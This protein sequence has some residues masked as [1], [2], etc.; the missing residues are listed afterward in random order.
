[1][2]LTDWLKRVMRRRLDDDDL[3]DEIRAHLAMA[4]RERMADGADPKTARQASLKEFGNV[5]LTTE[6]ARQVWTPRWVETLRNIV[7]DSRYAVRSLLKNPV[8]SLTVVAVLTLGIG[9]NAAVFTMVKSM[10]LTPLAGVENSA[11]LRVVYGETSAGRDVGISYPDYQYL[12]DHDTATTGMFAHRFVIV[13]MG[14]GRSAHPAFAEAVT[15][16]YF[17]KLGVRAAFGRVFSADDEAAP[18][19][20]S[21]AV[22][23]HALWRRELAA[24]P[25]IVGKTIE[26][27]NQLLTIVG[28]AAPAFH[29]MIVSYDV[30]VFLPVT[31]APTLGVT[32][33]SNETTPSGIL[34]DRRAT[35]LYAFGWLRPGVSMK[36]ASAEYDAIWTDASRGRTLE[37]GMTKMT[38]APFLKYP[39]SAQATVFP[40]LVALTAMATLVLV[41]ACANIGGLVVVR[42]VSRRGEIA[43]RL[44]LGA[45]RVRIVR[46]LIVENL[47]LAIPGAFLGVLLAAQAM[48][49]LFGFAVAMAAPN[50]LFFNMQTDML[51]IGFAA[52]VACASA[53]IFGFAPALRSARVDL[54]SVMNEESSR[55]SGRSG[56]RS[57]LVVAQVAVSLLLLIGAGLV[58][59]SLEAAQRAD[60]GFA[61]DHVTAINMDLKAN[62]YDDAR[63]KIFYRQLLKTARAQPGVESAS[64][65]TF[66]P[67][68]FLDTRS[69][70][71]EIDGYEPGRDE[72][73]SMLSNTVGP[74]YFRT[75]RIK[76]IAGREFADRD[77]EMAQPVAVVNKT[78]ADKFWGSA[79]S[80]IGRKVQMA[81]GDWRTVIGVAA[82]IKYIRVNEA[83]RPYIY[84]PF[85]QSYRAGMA[86][87][88]RGTASTDVLV[89][90]ARNA[91]ASLDADLPITSARS[92]SDATRGA[93]LFYTFM[94]SML[95]I[96]GVAGMAL[97]AMGTYGLVAYTV[98]E[99]THEIGIR[100][101]LGASGSDVMRA[102]LGRGLKLGL[103]GIVLGTLAAFAVGRLLQAVLF[104]VSATDLVS[105]ARALAIVLG[106]VAA[107]T[108]VPAWKASRTNPLTAL[109]HH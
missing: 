92:L 102:F 3:Q 51:V 43:L 100:M 13:T 83:P 91:V 82:D 95:F 10:A 90:Q 35:V 9:V 27:N 2:S 84:V 20:P 53:M 71:V 78:L 70:K 34:N 48:P 103:I 47:V 79:T 15:G 29:G 101:A 74:D 18:G 98:K 99:S 59:R 39:G 75:L 22:I 77:D 104:G 8:F 32:F 52:L 93:L 105:F 17:E 30:D 56:F 66:L 65:A 38:L 16:N 64:L 37:G 69:T 6:A 42:G 60:R 57:A 41:I 96:F 33:S 109:R 23:S 50:R 106:V 80:A 87:H 97:A 24:D 11:A 62:G 40:M 49:Y 107:A 28:V 54:V 72:D 36:Q 73:L 68:A 63:G 12:R 31:I 61:V 5:T 25:A 58:T 67:L 88:T 7:G 1:M 45:S 85:L 46:L 86:L 89:E 44:A 94:S 76:M 19:R 4:A 55:G 81:G 21:I 14:R 108:V 26:I